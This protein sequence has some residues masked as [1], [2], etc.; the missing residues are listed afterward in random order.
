MTSMKN[1]LFRRGDKNGTDVYFAPE[2][3]WHQKP[4]VPARADEVSRAKDTIGN[5][6]GRS[7]SIRTAP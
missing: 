6:V 4:P 2:D 3:G 1:L 5:C 7:K